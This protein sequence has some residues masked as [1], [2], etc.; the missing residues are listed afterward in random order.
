MTSLNNNSFLQNY[1]GAE[2]NY[3][4]CILNHES[5]YE[6]QSATILNPSNYHVPLSIFLDLS[7]RLVP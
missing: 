6:E 7:K 5:E 1:G 3:L 2:I 4:R